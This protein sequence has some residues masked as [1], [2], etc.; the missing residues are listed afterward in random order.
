MRPH[1]EA[2]QH[3]EVILRKRM[4]YDVATDEEKQGFDHSALYAAVEFL[5]GQIRDDKTLNVDFLSGQG[6]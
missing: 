3:F 6:T 4:E 1:N 5:L 2:A